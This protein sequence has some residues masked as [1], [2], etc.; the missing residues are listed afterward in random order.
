[1]KRDCI[2]LGIAFG[3]INGLLLGCGSPADQTTIPSSPSA[4]PTA[5]NSPSTV[6]EQADLQTY[7]NP[8]M[9]IATQYPSTMTIEDTCSGE[10]CG[11]FFR[12][13][14]QG[15]ALD[16]SEVHIFLAAG[17]R[18]AA[19][20]EQN[21]N[22]LIESNGWQIVPDATP[23]QEFTYP[24]VSKTITF[25]DETGM[26]GHILIGET[27]GQGVQ[28]TLRYPAEMF[29]TFLPAAQTILDNLQFKADKLPIDSQG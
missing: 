15:N 19:D 8:V 4:S 6:P 22:S 2:A 26:T 1:M 16:Q 14:P 23:P 11:Y 12:F 10:G 5:S 29:D 9:A 24:W 25:A 7:D 21:A 13:Q 3:V 27:N 20:S 18:S 17:A 28:V